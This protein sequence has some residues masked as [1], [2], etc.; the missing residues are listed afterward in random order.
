MSYNPSR[1]RNSATDKPATRT[2]LFRLVNPAAI[3][4]D[5]LGTFKSPAKNSTHASFAF[6][7]TGGAVRETF[8]ASPTSP[9]IAF[10]LARGCT[11]TANVTPSACS[12]IEITWPPPPELEGVIPKT[13]RTLQRGE[14]SGV[15]RNSVP[16]NEAVPA[17]QDQLTHSSQTKTQFQL[18]VIQTPPQPVDSRTSSRAQC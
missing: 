12:R 9:V 13:A 16:L 14:E 10:F 18:Q 5:A 17:C 7:S 11:R 2:T 1:F 3:L 4:T 6:P 8:N 15:D